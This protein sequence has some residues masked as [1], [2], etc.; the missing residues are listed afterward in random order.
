MA[1]EETMLNEVKVVKF[2]SGDEERRRK[3]LEAFPQR[4]ANDSH[5]IRAACQHYMKILEKELQVKV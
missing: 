3:Y 4:W 5:F 2:L 1:S